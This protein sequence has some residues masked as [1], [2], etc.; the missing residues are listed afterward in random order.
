MNLEV[1]DEDKENIDD[2]MEHLIDSVVKFKSS[3][4]VTPDDFQTLLNVLDYA[5]FIIS[6][7][8]YKYDIIFM[9]EED[10]DDDE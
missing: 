3:S 9:T 2:T 10:D 4:E 1:D 7:V 8:C 5:K 6:G